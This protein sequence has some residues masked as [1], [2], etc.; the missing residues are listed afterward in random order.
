MLGRNERDPQ[1]ASYTEWPVPPGVSTAAR[2]MCRAVFGDFLVEAGRSGGRWSG[3]PV[4][5]SPALLTAGLEE[6]LGVFRGCVVVMTKW[7][8]ID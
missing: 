3:G 7:F 1:T 4:H 6:L 5:Q 2:W 8:V